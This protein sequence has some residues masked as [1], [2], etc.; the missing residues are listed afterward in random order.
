MGPFPCPLER[1]RRMYRYDILLRT[2]TAAE[3]TKL[4]DY[5]RHEKK[6]HAKVKRMIIDIDP[7]SLL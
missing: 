2:G 1:I 7:V 3:R 6:L 5:L 4:L